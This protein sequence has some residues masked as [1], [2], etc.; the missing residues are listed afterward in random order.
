MQLVLVLLLVLLAQI[1][2]GFMPSNRYARSAISLNAEKKEVRKVYA[3]DFLQVE[4]FGS[5]CTVLPPS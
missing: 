2:Y 3:G 4:S 1:S 5:F